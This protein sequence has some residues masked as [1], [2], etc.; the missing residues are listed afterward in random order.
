MTYQIK[1]WDACFENN[2]SRERDHCSF[3]CVPNKQHGLGFCRVVSHL[4]GAA[5]YGNWQMIVGACSQQSKPRAGW[6]THNGRPDGTPW[7]AADLALKFR[8]PVKEIELAL[9]VLSSPEVDWLTTV[10][11]PSSARVVPVECPPD[12]LER[13]KEVKEVKEQKPAGADLICEQIY[14]AYPK[15]A[16]RP[17]ALQEIRRALSKISGA[18]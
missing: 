4:R 9:K 15:K 5:I 1:N 3:V 14:D 2:K 17:K 7:T 6:L 10:E 13:K 18:D 11:C 16:G 12:T 8:R